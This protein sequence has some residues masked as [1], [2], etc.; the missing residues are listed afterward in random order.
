MRSIIG[1]PTGHR[2]WESLVDLNLYRRQVTR[3]SIWIEK[4]SLEDIIKLLSTYSVTKHM[5]N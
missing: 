3:Q 2:S 1:S 5:V 4:N